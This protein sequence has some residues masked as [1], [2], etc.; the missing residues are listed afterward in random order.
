MHFAKRTDA[1]FDGR[2]LSEDDLD[3]IE[4]YWAI[5]SRKSLWAFRQ[6][7]DPTLAKGWWVAEM[8]REFQEFFQ[9]MKQGQRPKL[10]IEAP[11]QHGKSRGLIDA[12]AWFA[13]LDANLKT[14]YC[15]FSD[16]LGTR[17]N[18]QLQRMWGSEKWARTFP[19]VR[20]PYDKEQEFSKNSQLIEFPGYRGYFLNTTVKGQVT[21]KTAG[22]GVVDDPLKGREEAMSKLQRDKAWNWMLDDFFSRFTDDAGFI[23]TMTRWHV[24]DPAGRWIDKFPDTRV[25]KFPALYTPMPE[26]W[27]NDARDPRTVEGEP[28]FPQ[29]KS[30]GFLLERKSA[31]TASSWQSLYQ[32]M[33]IVAGGGMFPIQ[34]F[35]RVGV[36]PTRSEIKKMVRYWDKAGTEAGGAYTAGVLMAALQDGRWMVL[37]VVRGQW[38]SLEREQV[39]LKTTQ[40]DRVDYGRVETWLEQEPG[41]GGKESAERSIAMLAGYPAK[42]DKVS[43][44]KEIRAEP[45]AAQQQAGHILVFDAPWTQPFIDEHEPFPNGKYKDQVDSAAGAFM[46]LVT[47]TYKYDASL[48]WVGGPNR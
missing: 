12:I 13:G 11:P 38:S 2:T 34:K 9:R 47:K 35:K 23:L 19:D 3:L 20:L 22:L 4:Q 15:S 36:M 10:L 21:G 46:K 39:I 31:Y 27:K 14:I 41:S 26:G 48:S 7:M 6:Y 43:G 16:D 18:N 28:L 25:L 44:S 29:F 30:K 32:Q 45:Y 17:A 8:S 37:N 5:E 40:D 24:D 33:P 1:L 42:A